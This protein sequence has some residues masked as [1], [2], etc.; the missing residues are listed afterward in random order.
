MLREQR[1]HPRVP[2][3]SSVIIRYGKDSRVARTVDISEGGVGLK[4]SASLPRGQSVNLMLEL[5]GKVVSAEARVLRWEQDRYGLTF[6]Q[7][8]DDS[9]EVIRATVAT[10]LQAL[11]PT[12]PPALTAEPPTRPL[13][14][15][16]GALRI[17]VVDDEPSTLLLLKR[18]LERSGHQVETAEDAEVA[19]MALRARPPDVLVTDKNLPRMSGLELLT[20]ARELQPALAVMLITAVPDAAAVGQSKIDFYLPKPFRKL[21]DVEDG[22]RAAVEHRKA[23]LQRE[24]N[25]RQLQEVIARLSPAK[26]Q[27]S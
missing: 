17:L 1:I 2:V 6:T 5:T 8:S 10:R 18:V 4:T 21:S 11:R 25:Q 14:N 15:A 3:E 12:A 19:L 27:S 23:T 13:A 22:V 24:L 7:L 16:V 9:L 26:K 20:S